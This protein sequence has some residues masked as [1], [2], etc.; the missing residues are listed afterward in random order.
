[1]WCGSHGS[2]IGSAIPDLDVRHDL[3][4]VMAGQQA[5]EN[6]RS[7][8]FRARR[9]LGPGGG[10]KHNVDSRRATAVLQ[11][12]PTS[13]IH[14][15]HHMLP[16]NHVAHVSV[17]NLQLL[18]APQ[19]ARLWCAAKNRSGAQNITARRYMADPEATIRLRHTRVAVRQPLFIGLKRNHS[20]DA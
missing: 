17:A 16:Q 20:P 14:S 8:L 1:M 18:L 13:E 5:L 10:V 19:T 7:V 11:H 15:L 3:Q 4:V 12:D 2:E 9:G 6:E